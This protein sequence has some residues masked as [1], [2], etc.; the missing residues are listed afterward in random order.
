MTA[1]HTAPASKDQVAFNHVGHCVADLGISRRFYQEL[2][3]FAFKTEFKVPDQPA[4]QLLG[5]EPPLGMTALY[6]QLG[7]LVLELMEFNR[8]G[9]PAYQPRPVN[10]PGLTHISLGVNDVEAVLTR[11]ALYGGQVIETT[12]IGVAVFIRDPDGQLIELL[13][14]R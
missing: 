12:N 1:A 11:V 4:A 5:I 6:L 7:G 13:P 9:N 10:Q 3:G 14:T 2:F 8:P